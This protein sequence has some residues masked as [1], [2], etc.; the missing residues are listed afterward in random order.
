MMAQ[1]KKG[2]QLQRMTKERKVKWKENKMDEPVN[3]EKKGKWRRDKN[4][5]T[6]SE[7]DEPVNEEKKWKTKKR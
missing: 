5:R 1:E 6:M 3:E 4:N 2:V 7:I